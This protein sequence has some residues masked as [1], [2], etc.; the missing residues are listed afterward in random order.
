VPEDALA[1]WP[2]TRGYDLLRSYSDAVNRALVDRWLPDEPVGRLL[3]TDAFDEA[4]GEGLFPLLRVRAREV[5]VVDVSEAAVAAARERHPGL[6]AECGDVRRLDFPDATFDAVVSNSTLDHFESLEELRVAVHELARVLR[7]GGRF[8]V[9]LDNPANPLVGF[10]NLL[11]YQLLRRLGILQYRMGVTCGARR[12]RRLVTE[13]GFD[14]TDVVALMHVPRVLALAL[15]KVFRTD[16][17]LPRLIA[18]ES[19]GRL[20]TRHLTGQFVGVRAIRH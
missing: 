1:R 18:A 10:R 8:I 19:L 6:A 14:V 20:P 5:V 12:L 7:P 17:L 15:A 9:T 4:A 2:Q 16:H 11:P 13:A 3:K